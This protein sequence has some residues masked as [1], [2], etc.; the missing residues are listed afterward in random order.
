M[1]KISKNRNNIFN[2]GKRKRRYTA[3]ANSGNL[4]SVWLNNS[5]VKAKKRVAQRKREEAGEQ[6]Q[7]KREASQ[8]KARERASRVRSNKRRREREK[9]NRLEQ[10]RIKKIYNNQRKEYNL[11]IKKIFS[12]DQNKIKKNIDLTIHLYE[13][14]IINSLR[15]FGPQLSE[16]N[17]IT[18]LDEDQ[19]LKKLLE[20]ST[21]PKVQEIL[22][23]ENDR[24]K[25]LEDKKIR[26]EKE[27]IKLEL[28]KKEK[29]ELDKKKYFD[30]KLKKELEI[31]KKIKIQTQKLLTENKIKNFTDKFIHK[32]ENIVFIAYGELSKYENSSRIDKPEK[33]YLLFTDKRL[34]FHSQGWFKDDLTEVP[35]SKVLGLERDDMRITYSLSFKI[36]GNK[37]LVFDHID[38]DYSKEKE[39]RILF[40]NYFV[41]KF[42]ELKLKFF[43]GGEW[44]SDLELYDDEDD[45][46]D[47]AW[48]NGLSVEKLK[49]DFEKFKL[50]K[51]KELKVNKKQEKEK[52]E[53]KELKVNKKQEKETIKN[54][55]LKVNKKQERKID[56]KK[57]LE[58]KISNFVQK[59]IKFLMSKNKVKNL[60]NK[61]INKDEVVKF[62]DYGTL[63]VSSP[64][65]AGYLILTDK[66]FL[67]HSKVLF[68]KESLTEIPLSNVS[69]VT[70]DKT[71]F[72]KENIVKFK[73][74]DQKDLVF[75]DLVDNLSDAWNVEE[76]SDLSIQ[77]LKL[78][79]NQ[80]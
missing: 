61:F 72:T 40:V 8:R 23:K 45:N 14:K 59:K 79:F 42:K 62:I 58:K 55:E 1:I 17:E 18:Q 11:L 25:R 67:F 10:A 51:N 4:G 15:T 56:K 60:I 66:R 3:K 64:S 37:S 76:N 49:E 33:G 12:K 41:L 53:N 73:I 2:I 50:E 68:L 31:Y 20:I 75:K 39:N 28:I 6:R 34:L 9:E 77:Y 78:K 5:I 80:N 70:F 69:G 54:K 48:D 16:S 36:R 21:N 32:N 24:V 43:E 29:L 19:T 71:S 7:K 44:I 30:E 22:T 74:K 13:Q 46:R 27:R 38:E 47:F 52:T 63:N 26:Q 65:P 35:L 57:E